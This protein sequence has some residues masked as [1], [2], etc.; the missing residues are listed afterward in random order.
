MNDVAPIETSPTPGP[1]PDPGMVWIPGGTFLMGSDGHYPEE[2]PAHRVRVDGFWMD[3]YTVTNRDFARFVDSDRLRHPGREAGEGRGLSGRQ[4]GIA[5]A[6]LG[7]LPEGG[8]ARST[9]AIHYNWWTYVRGADWRHPRGPASSIGKLDDHPVVHVAF[10]DAVAYAK[11]AGKELPTEAEWEFAARGGL[12]GA[13]Y[14][15]GDEF[16]PGGRSHGQHL[17]GRVSLPTTCSR[18]ATSGPRR[19][20]RFRPTA[21]ASTTWPAMSGSGRP[22]GTQE[23]GRD[24]QSLLHHRKSAR[25]RARSELRSAHAGRAGSP[26]G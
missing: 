13:E 8:A 15:W 6:V 3:R 1:P 11:W 20:A 2:A 12:D 25:R 14:A 4:A 7:R 18:T 21:T 10:E 9:W 5:R 24:R 23:H 26:A 17:A 19:S 16:T 22:T